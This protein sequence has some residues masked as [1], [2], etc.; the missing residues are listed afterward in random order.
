MS[1]SG[2]DDE[3][4]NRKGAHRLLDGL[5][6]YF[7]RA[8][9]PLQCGHRAA[10]RDSAGNPLAGL[11]GPQSVAAQIEHQ[12]T[13]ESVKQAQDR[14][15]EKFSATMARAKRLDAKGNRS[16][17]TSALSAAKRMYIL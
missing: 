14:L 15:R 8:R 13:Q 5:L 17:C 11:T 9:R 16:G 10:I 4:S 1:G 2:N 3:I 6:E 12:P 7:G